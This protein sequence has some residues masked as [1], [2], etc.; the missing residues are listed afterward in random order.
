MT[1]IQEVT[2]QIK[3]VTGW[4]PKGMTLR[5]AFVACELESVIVYWGFWTDKDLATIL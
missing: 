2:E 5:Q 4:N 3:E 1:R